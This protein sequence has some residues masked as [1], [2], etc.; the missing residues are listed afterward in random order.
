MV[1]FSTV[2]LEMGS[3]MVIGVS[4]QYKSFDLRDKEVANRLDVHNFP[5]RTDI[6]RVNIKRS[7]LISSRTGS[8]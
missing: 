7:V 5:C 2:E 1:M 3:G 8:K 6:K 4:Q